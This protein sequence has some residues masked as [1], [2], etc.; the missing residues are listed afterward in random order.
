MPLNFLGTVYRET[1]QSLIDM[2]AMFAL[3]KEQPK[4]S[5]A[6]DA[7]AL[8]NGPLDVEF[9][10]ASF[11]SDH[12]LCINTFM[13][14]ELL[15]IIGVMDARQQVACMGHWMFMQHYLDRQGQCPAV[16]HEWTSWADHVRVAQYQLYCLCLQVPPRLQYPEGRVVQGPC[17][18]QL[19]CGWCEWERQEHHP[20][21]A[22]Q[23]RLLGPQLL[24][25]PSAHARR[26]A[27]ATPTG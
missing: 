26:P 11:R 14:A 22:L 24:A 2:G 16:T 27:L 3:L 18:H 9:R 20:E 6:P 15:R 8:P 10:D 17:W 21:D 25:A 12:C 19:C 5:D 13:H 7:I 4:L 1:K 23:V